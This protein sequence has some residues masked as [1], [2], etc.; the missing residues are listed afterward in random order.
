M[1]IVH[2]LFDVMVIVI[3]TFIANIIDLSLLICNQP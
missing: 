1:H 2:Y 3:D